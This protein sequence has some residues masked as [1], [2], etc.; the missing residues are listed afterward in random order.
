ME[1][2]D[3]NGENVTEVTLP[4]SLTL[5]GPRATNYFEPFH[6]VCFGIRDLP[7]FHDHV[8]GKHDAKSLDFLEEVLEFVANFH[9]TQLCQFCCLVV[10]SFTCPSAPLI[11]IIDVVNRSHKHHFQFTQAYHFQGKGLCI[12]NYIYTLHPKPQF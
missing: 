6:M 5:E 9:S 3:Y 12:Y 11:S 10:P 4:Y 2:G 7:P 8:H 1:T